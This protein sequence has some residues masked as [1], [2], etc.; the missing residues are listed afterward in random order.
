ME[1]IK[2]TEEGYGQQLIELVK[3][4]HQMRNS[5][6]EFFGMYQMEC[7]VLFFLD[8]CKSA[9]TMSARAK[10]SEVTKE[11]DIPKP[12]TSKLINSLEEQE[13]VIRSMDKTDRRV[14]YIELTEKGRNALEE[15]KRKR[16]E[17]ANNLMSQLGEEDAKELM[18][19][20]DKLY[21]IVKNNKE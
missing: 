6:K 16:N 14:I 19:I 5:H 8:R 13:Y 18:R 10:I 11:L 3:K 2:G 17:I 4:I 21:N 12:A 15:M 20:V 1:V 7:A 9:G